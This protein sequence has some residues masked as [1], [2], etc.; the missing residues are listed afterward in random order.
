MVSRPLRTKSAAAAPLFS[1][2]FCVRVE[3]S[4]KVTDIKASP[5]SAA[6]ESNGEASEKSKKNTAN[7]ARFNIKADTS[8][9]NEHRN[10]T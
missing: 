6:R 3:D 9:S 1:M 7:T 4:P 2:R 10:P 5:L 8:F